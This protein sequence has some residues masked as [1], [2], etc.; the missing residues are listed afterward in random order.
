MSCSDLLCGFANLH[1][2][3]CWTTAEFWFWWILFSIP[4]RLALEPSHTPI[5]RLQKAV[6]RDHRDV[7]QTAHLHLLPMLRMNEPVPTLPHRVWPWIKYSGKFTHTLTLQT[8]QGIVGVAIHYG[9]NGPVSNPGEIE[10]FSNPSGPA[11]WPT[12]PPIKRVRGLFPA[13]KAAGA[14]S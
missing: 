12:Q 5:H 2:M 9:L 1:K 7:K 14:W 6:P 4:S 11:L 8:L 13:G 3:R 10:I